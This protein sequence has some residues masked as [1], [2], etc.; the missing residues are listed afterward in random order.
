[1]GMASI[2]GKYRWY[3]ECSGSVHRCAHRNQ[4]HAVQQRAEN[5]TSK[6]WSPS[7]R[8]TNKVSPAQNRG[9]FVSKKVTVFLLFWMPFFAFFYLFL[10]SS[11]RWN[12]LKSKALRLIQKETGGCFHGNGLIPLWA[13]IFLALC[14]L[15]FRNLLF[16]YCSSMISMAQFSLFAE[17]WS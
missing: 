8:I 17:G 6:W 11:K 3:A 12:P 16:F 5:P 4:F 10:L 13:L 9:V 7:R 14:D 15:L 2:C 1:M